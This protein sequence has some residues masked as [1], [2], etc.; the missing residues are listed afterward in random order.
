MTG[1][2]ISGGSFEV[3]SGGERIGLRRAIGSSD[4]ELLTGVADRYARAVLAGSD[5]GVFAGLGRELFGWLEGD[6]GQLSE[7]L[8]RSVC[9]VVFEVQGPRSPSDG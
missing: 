7:V 4:V 3:L 6:Q 9:P 8:D 5:A 2:V 1:L